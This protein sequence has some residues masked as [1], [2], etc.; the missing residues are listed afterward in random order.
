MRARQVYDAFIERR[1]SEASLR[2]L[3]ERDE[4]R[5]RASV[6]RFFGIKT[7]EVTRYCKMV[8]WALE[9]EDYHRD[10]DRDESQIANRT[11]AL[12]QYFYELDSGRG[13]DKLA[14]KLRGDDGFRE[15]VFDLMFD[16]K[17]KNWAQV[18]DLRRVYDN[19]ESLD[20]LKQAHRETDSTIG[21]ATVNRAIDIARRAKYGP[22]TGRSGRR[23]GPHHQVAQRGVTLAVL[24]KLDPDV[25]REFR[26]AARAVER[27]DQ[28][29]GRREQRTAVDAGAA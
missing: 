3:T 22:A 29:P 23:V 7:Q 27:H 2:V 19:P 12:F 6:A 9:F 25:L 20:E 8:V 26:D 1:D 17:F 16:G 15:I 13:D 11:N 5:I 4:T 18:R 24:R 10:Q 21:R 14:V 28:L